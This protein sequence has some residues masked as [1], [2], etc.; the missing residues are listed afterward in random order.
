MEKPYPRSGMIR[1][2]WGRELVSIFL[3]R[4][5][6]MKFNEDKCCVK[7]L[8]LCNDS[9]YLS[10]K[11][12]IVRISCQPVNTPMSKMN[13]KETLRTLNASSSS[14]VS[15]WNEL[16]PFSGLGSGCS[17]EPRAS[18]HGGRGDL[19]LMRVVCLLPLSKDSAV[20]HHSTLTCHQLYGG[21]LFLEEGLSLCYTGA[22][23][24]RR[25]YR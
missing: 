23:F 12:D 7:D 25:N 10:N 14:A 4:E 8:P 22:F 19:L 6:S 1:G 2:V 24:V 17:Q 11:R 9:C 18:V 21:D 16:R 13:R 3:N 5:K 15:Y 20:E